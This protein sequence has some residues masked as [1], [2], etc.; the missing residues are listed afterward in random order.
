MKSLRVNPHRHPES[1]RRVARRAVGSQ[2]VERLT[3]ERSQIG[4]QLGIGGASSRKVSDG[5]RTRDR[6]DHKQR[7][8]RVRRSDSQCRSESGIRADRF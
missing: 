8:G 7:V 2:L 1:V 5:T 3:G 6:L 4:R